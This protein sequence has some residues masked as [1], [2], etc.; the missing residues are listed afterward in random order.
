MAETK[1]RARA[2]ASDQSAHGTGQ[3]PLSLDQ[4]G[5]LADLVAELREMS[6]RAGL[7]TL[8]GILALAQSEAVQQIAIRR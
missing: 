3:V 2:N 4:L 1:Q 7:T 6:D 5:Y 8:A